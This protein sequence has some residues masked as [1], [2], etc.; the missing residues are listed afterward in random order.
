MGLFKEFT[1]SVSNILRAVN[2]STQ[3][4]DIAASSVV[5]LAKTGKVLSE[6]NL[7]FVTE[8]SAK[9]HLIDMAMLDIE[10]NRARLLAGLPPLVIDK[11]PD[12]KSGK[13]TD[14]ENDSTI[15]LGNNG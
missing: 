4:L 14:T 12:H 2:T 13:D 8:S 5:D 6:A 15:Y 7:K 11:N 9:E 3:A 1:S 10:I